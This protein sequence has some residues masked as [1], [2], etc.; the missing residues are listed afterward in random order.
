M[1]GYVAS[2]RCDSRNSCDT[3]AASATA[4]NSFRPRFAT[5]NH[6]G[7]ASSDFIQS[8]NSSQD[9]ALA[10]LSWPGTTQTSTGPAGSSSRD[11]RMRSRVTTPVTRRPRVTTRTSRIRR[12]AGDER[13][14]LETPGNRVSRGMIMVAKSMA[15]HGLRRKAGL[16]RAKAKAVTYSTANQPMMPHWTR[17][18]STFPVGVSGNHICSSADATATIARKPKNASPSRKTNNDINLPLTGNGTSLLSM[19]QLTNGESRVK[20]QTALFWIVLVVESQ[21][22]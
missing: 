5:L 3:S 7:A 13:K 10:D 4:F 2:T 20:R 16:E 6:L 14:A 22:R 21:R 17:L 11:W 1:C 15:R 12:R 18:T 9:E 19:K 8:R